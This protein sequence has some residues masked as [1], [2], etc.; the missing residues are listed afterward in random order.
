MTTILIRINPRLENDNEVIFFAGIEAGHRQMAGAIY[1]T[2]AEVDVLLD[3]LGLPSE[4]LPGLAGSVTV[5]DRRI[6]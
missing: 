4:L 1:L 2:D 3:G 5:E 6:T